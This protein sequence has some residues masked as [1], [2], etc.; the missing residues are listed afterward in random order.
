MDSRRTVQQALPRFV[1]VRGYRRQTATA[2]LLYVSAPVQLCS[3]Y[4]S[5]QQPAAGWGLAIMATL[6][7]TGWVVHALW[8]HRPGKAEGQAA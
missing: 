8:T 1:S 7:L 3:V 4:L 6:V 5:E 2:G